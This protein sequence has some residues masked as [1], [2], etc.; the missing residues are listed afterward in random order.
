MV[1]AGDVA[2][3]PGLVPHHHG[4][5]LPRQE[6]AVRLALVP[7]LVELQEEETAG[8]VKAQEEAGP[9]TGCE[10]LTRGFPSDQRKSPSMVLSFSPIH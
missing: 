3:A 6:V 7:V 2:P 1:V 9:A 5:V 8:S 4:A 10:R